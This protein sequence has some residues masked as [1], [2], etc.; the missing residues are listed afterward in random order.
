MLSRG[1]FLGLS[2]F[3]W[4]LLLQTTLAKRKAPQVTLA[5]FSHSPSLL[6]SSSTPSFSRLCAAAH[7]AAVES[8][9]TSH[10]SQLLLDMAAVPAVVGVSPGYDGAIGSD[11]GKGP[12]GGLKTEPYHSSGSNVDVSFKHPPSFNKW[13]SV[14][15]PSHFG[16]T[17]Q[18]NRI[19]GRV[20]IAPPTTCSKV[21]PFSQLHLYNSFYESA[22]LHLRCYNLTI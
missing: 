9:A 5:T 4:E 12:V 8:A 10:V 17:S 7:A 21:M 11:G 15:S 20:S 19:R 1:A 13:L 16:Y 14:L 2:G 18:P 22:T 6:F 3:F